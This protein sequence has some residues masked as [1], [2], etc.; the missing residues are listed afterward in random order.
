MA[1]AQ[2]V[3]SVGEEV[4]LAVLKGLVMAV[5]TFARWLGDL[6]AGEPEPSAF[7]R[8]VQDILPERSLSREAADR[9]AKDSSVP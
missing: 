7:S 4:A 8:R 6:L 9:L 5:P 3:S 2:P 1:D